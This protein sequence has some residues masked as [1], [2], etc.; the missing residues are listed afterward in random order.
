MLPEDPITAIMISFSGSF[1]GGT[2]VEGGGGPAGKYA[3]G[4]GWDMGGTAGILGWHDC[5]PL[6]SG[7]PDIRPP[8]AT[9]NHSSLW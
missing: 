8:V 7:A 2:I 1:I 9:R 4:L 5:I 6:V 3:E